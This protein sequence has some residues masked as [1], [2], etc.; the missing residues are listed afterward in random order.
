MILGPDPGL[1]LR[2][3]TA[4]QF[5]L[6]DDRAVRKVAHSFFSSGFFDNF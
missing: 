1:F 4:E 3:V 2:V 5:P 6:L